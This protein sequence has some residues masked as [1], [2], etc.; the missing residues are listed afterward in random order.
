M[1]PHKNT[2]FFKLV[3]LTGVI[4]AGKSIV[5]REFEKLGVVI[6]DADTLSRDAVKPGSAA[7]NSI[8]LEF[9]KEILA[10]NGELDRARMGEIVFKDPE[11]RR[12]LEDIVHPE[13]RR[14]FFERL[15]TIKK[16]YLS[17]APSEKPL[18]VYIVPLLFESR[19]SYEELEKIIVVSAARETCIQRIIERDKCPRELAE[20]KLDSQ[21]PIEEKEKR[22]DFLI[23]NEGSIEDL[24]QQV[25][26][27]YQK[28]RV[29]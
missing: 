24:S 1:K 6:I 3:G 9:G 4:G 28:I 23:R 29:G 22:A 11:K 7:L 20:R 17:T 18:V 16:K 13:V 25:K 12:V 5:G 27:I 2:Q 15:S 19:F 26:K 10:E 8:Q 14:L 21:L